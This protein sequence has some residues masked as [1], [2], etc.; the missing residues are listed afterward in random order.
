MATSYAKYGIRASAIAP[1]WAVT[2]FHLGK[3]ANPEER[4]KELEEMETDS[5]IMSHK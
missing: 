2:E 3:A 5:F 1:G 4:K